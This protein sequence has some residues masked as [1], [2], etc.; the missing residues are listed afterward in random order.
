VSHQVLTLIYSNGKFYVSDVKVG[1]GEPP[2]ISVDKYPDG[3]PK[4]MYLPVCP[5]ENLEPGD[6]VNPRALTETFTFYTLAER[7]R[8]ASIWGAATSDIR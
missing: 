1:L 4:V 6:I 2:R 5:G 3:T 7:R 8:I